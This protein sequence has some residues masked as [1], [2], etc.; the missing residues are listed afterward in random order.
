[1][2]LWGTLDF[3]LS[4]AETL[5]LAATCSD[6]EVAEAGIRLKRIEADVDIGRH[7]ALVRRLGFVHRVDT[8]VAAG[9]I[10][11]NLEP[12]FELGSLDLRV[13]LADP[14]PWFFGLTRPYV[15]VKEAQAYGSAVVSGDWRALQLDGRIR[16]SRAALYVPSIDAS[17][18]RAQAEITLA[19]DQIRVD[20]LSG[21][22]T[23]GLVTVT[24]VYDMAPGLLVDSL[25]FLV[26]FN[27]AAAS[28]IP[29]VYAIG[30]GEISVS[31]RPGEQTLIAGRVDVEE[32]LV[33]MSFGGGGNAAQPAGDEPVALD[34]DIR[35]ERGIWL[36]NRDAD[37]EL[38]VD[39]RIK[40]SRAGT[41][42][43][44][45]LTSRQGSVYYLDHILRVTN[46]VMGFENID[47]F[48]PDLDI[49]AE[50]PVRNHGN[51]A[52]DRI[53]LRLTGTLEHP[54]FDFASEPAVWDA[55]Q[56]VSYMSLNV[57]ADELTAMEQ[58]DVVTRMV[59]QR[60]L[61]YF[62]TRVARQVREYVALD[63]LEVETGL[64]GGHGASVTVGKYIGRNLYV[65]YSQ[66]F[67]SQLQ[68]AFTVQ[69]YL[70][71]RSEVLAERSVDGRY[72]LRYQFRLR[73]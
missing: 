10:A 50:L 26:R 31:W 71:R 69:Y 61:G 19:G 25:R 27:G 14:G 44:G 22:S 51:G 13:D 33:A 20:K 34:L 46:G 53:L 60:L 64:A 40:Q 21:R 58:K 67:S 24:G 49:T 5:R 28:P 4:G 35:G 2:E 32:A 8:T 43:A 62:Q 56:I 16:V 18:D 1:T 66:N 70:D 47:R 7:G 72:S 65:S 68:P 30:G 54:E 37:I 55:G 59:T 38:A 6:F 17:V 11:Y 42:Y 48:N 73:Y 15:E 12:K 41:V 52:P 57:T 23:R 45:R 36:R 9:N 39:L 29:D 63:Y 3:K